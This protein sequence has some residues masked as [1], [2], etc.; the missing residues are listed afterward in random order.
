MALDHGRHSRNC[1][2]VSVQKKTGRPRRDAPHGLLSYLVASAAAAAAA[3]TAA[4][5]A[6]ARLVVRLV[7]AQ[8]TSVEVRS[9]EGLDCRVHVVGVAHLDE[10]ETAR[11]ARFAVHDDAYR[12]DL[13]VV[14]CKQIVQILL[15]GVKRDVSD[16]DFRAQVWDSF[17]SRC[18]D[19]V[20]RRKG[21]ARNRY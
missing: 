13:T 1:I 5:T 10:C 9:V 7:D 2:W 20:N 3:A 15:A 8:R 17:R 18:L 14:G 12:V 11:A 6:T 19:L 21:R 16:K 4:A